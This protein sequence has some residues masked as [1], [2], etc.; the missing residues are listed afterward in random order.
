MNG[1][2]KQWGTVANVSNNSSTTVSV[3]SFSN[4]NYNVFFTESYART[5]GH[6]KFFTLTSRNENSFS[7]RMADYDALN[8]ADVLWVAI[9]Y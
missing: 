5:G 9:G 4:Q 2:I 7:F 8:L 1:L 6:G 3:I